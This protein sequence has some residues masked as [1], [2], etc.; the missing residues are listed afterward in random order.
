MIFRDKKYFSVLFCAF[1]NEAKISMHDPQVV[2]ATAATKN[3]PS[4]KQ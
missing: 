4:K 3:S 2:A 1:K